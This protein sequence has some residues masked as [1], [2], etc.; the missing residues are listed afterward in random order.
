MLQLHER[1]YFSSTL[2]AA[3]SSRCMIHRDKTFLY[4]PR[5]LTQMRGNKYNEVGGSG[6]WV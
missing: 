4:W 5:S 6:L 3:L 2:P 1:W